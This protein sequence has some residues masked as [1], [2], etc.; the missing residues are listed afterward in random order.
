LITLILAASKILKFPATS[1]STDLLKSKL[2]P[3]MMAIGTAS[4]AILLQAA[5]FFFLARRSK[6]SA[7][8]SSLVDSSTSMTEA[9]AGNPRTT[10]EETKASSPTCTTNVIPPV[11]N[12][13]EQNTIFSS[14]ARLEELA[15]SMAQKAMTT[16]V[17]LSAQSELRELLVSQINNVISGDLIRTIRERYGIDRMESSFADSKSRISGVI[18]SLRLRNMTVFLTGFLFAFCGIGSLVFFVMKIQ[19]Q[20]TS[21]E[22]LVF[23]APHIVIVLILEVLAYFCMNLHRRGLSDL[24]YYQNELTNIESRE[25]ALH[26]ALLNGNESQVG[27][28]ISSLFATD[29]NAIHI[30][31]NAQVPR[32]NGNSDQLVAMEAISQ[33]ADLAKKM[34]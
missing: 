20:Q 16:P 32:R 5:I 27:G 1:W 9:D 15:A 2:P 11:A 33:I 4:A 30:I 21:G 12:Q 18:Q 31:N 26:A 10:E 34:S 6:R 14:I 22:R 8:L 29:R 13:A 7:T 19:M 25:A 23:F 3:D 17:D 28:L 24:R